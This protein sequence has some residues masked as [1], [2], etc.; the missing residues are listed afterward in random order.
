MPPM[1]TTHVHDVVEAAIP[2]P[3]TLAGY[4][5]AL[6]RLSGELTLLRQRLAG[7]VPLDE[8]LACRR[9]VE[10]S[11]TDADR[12]AAAAVRLLRD[13]HRDEAVI[14]LHQALELHEI[15]LQARPSQRIDHAGLVGSTR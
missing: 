5:A 9:R 7:S 14:V 10:I 12:L 6:D 1:A 11:E 4:A 8:A 2:E 13:P 15:D 3:G